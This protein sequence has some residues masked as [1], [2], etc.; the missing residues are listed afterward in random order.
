MASFVESS[1]TLKAFKLFILFCA[2]AA[3]RVQHVVLGFLDALLGVMK[4][5]VRKIARVGVAVYGSFP[6]L[7]D[8]H[9][10]PKIL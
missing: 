8:P 7:G 6:K 4:V 3:F 2:A 5:I 1:C 10:G 9:I